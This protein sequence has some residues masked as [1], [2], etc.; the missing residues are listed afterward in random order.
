LAADA[1]APLE[2]PPTDLAKLPPEQAAALAKLCL[3]I[4]NLNEFMFVD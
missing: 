1:A 3:A 4:L 2:D